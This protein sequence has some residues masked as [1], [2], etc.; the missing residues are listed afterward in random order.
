ML[1]LALGAVLKGQDVASVYAGN[2]GES[3]G[4]LAAWRVV[5]ADDLGDVGGAGFASQL[6]QLGGELCVVAVVVVHP[7]CDRML[8]C[9]VIHAPRYKQYADSMSTAFR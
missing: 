4:E 9:L 8:G 3:P 7:C 5:T 2:F 6:A 1:G